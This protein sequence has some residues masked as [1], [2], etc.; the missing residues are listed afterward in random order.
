MECH[1]NVF[2]T[3]DVCMVGKNI[4][5]ISP[6]S[7]DVLVF[8]NTL[9]LIP[10]HKYYLRTDLVQGVRGTRL[11][12]TGSPLLPEA[13]C[14][15]S[16]LEVGLVVVLTL[17]KRTITKLAHVGSWHANLLKLWPPPTQATLRDHKSLPLFWIL[18]FLWV[19]TSP[20]HLDINAQI[21]LR[22]LRWILLSLAVRSFDSAGYKK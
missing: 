21:G 14:G 7:E 19:L 1:P 3:L 15:R 17:W 5:R 12:G 18:Y 16:L 22:G 13:A 8:P 9:N 11:P 4:F 2:T 20:R 6:H 10:P